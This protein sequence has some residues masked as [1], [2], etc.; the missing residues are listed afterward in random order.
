LQPT[1]YAWFGGPHGTANL[2]R[3]LAEIVQLA[4]LTFEHVIVIVLKAI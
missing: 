4:G 1:I 2:P 3:Q